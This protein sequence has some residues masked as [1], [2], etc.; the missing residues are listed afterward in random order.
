MGT[1]TVMATQGIGFEVW[2]KF[3]LF[4]NISGTPGNFRYKKINRMN[5]ANSQET[6]VNCVLE[7]GRYTNHTFTH[8]NK[9]NINPNHVMLPTRRH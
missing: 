1:N 8:M 4:L 2:E 3:L 7:C 5:G 9:G 6:Q